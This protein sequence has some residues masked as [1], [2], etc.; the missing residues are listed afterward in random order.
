[1]SEQF[2]ASDD[3]GKIPQAIPTEKPL[4]MLAL[5]RDNFA[6]I[7]GLAVV[8]GA[9]LAIVFLF[10]YLSVFDWHLIAFIEYVDVITFGV[11]AAGVVSGSFTLAYNTVLYFLYIPAESKKFTRRR[12]IVDGGVAV[13]AFAL[14]VWLSI[15][16]HTGYFHVVSG[17]LVLGGVTFIA[18]RIIRHIQLKERP[19]M[20]QASSYVF[21]SLLTTGMCGQWAAYSVLESSRFDQNIR[22]KDW[23]F[24]AAKVVIVMSRFTVLL[25][26]Q[27]LYVVP[28]ADILQF[29][30]SG[31][32]I[33]ILPS[34]SASQTSP[35][36]SAHSP[37]VAPSA[38]PPSSPQGTAPRRRVVRRH[39]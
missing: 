21:I 7:S 4:D 29:R 35:A 32:L 14:Y 27:I 15:S 25:K 36:S 1:V 30:T 13:A 19:T 38:P 26:D 23:T 20:A 24:D 10:S 12:W 39:G 18:L 2:S 34:P 6:V 16:G 17:A 9:T 11:V 8:S 5:L 22:G 28:T 31:P 3:K 33:T 37:P